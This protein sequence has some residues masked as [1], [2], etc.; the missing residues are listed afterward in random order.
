M[1]GGP[2]GDLL[3]GQDGNDDLSGEGGTDSL[4]GGSG[5]NWCTVGSADSQ[6]RCVYDASAPKIGYATVSPNPVDV[7]TQTA[8]VTVRAHIVDDT[9]VA[10]VQFTW[11][12]PRLVCAT[13]SGRARQGSRGTRSPGTTR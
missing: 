9:G 4:D 8:V 2:D 6:T 3:S 10:H 5:T 13:A 1:L 12:T 7:T 11:G